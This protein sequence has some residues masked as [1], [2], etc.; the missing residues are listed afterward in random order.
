MGKGVQLKDLAK[1]MSMRSQ[2]VCLSITRDISDDDER[3]YYNA[4][5]EFAGRKRC[6]HKNFIGFVTKEYGDYWVW[7]IS[8]FTDDWGNPY[9]EVSAVKHRTE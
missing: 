1:V 8:L 6:D 7:D 5:C 2:P 3:L 9:I 4:D